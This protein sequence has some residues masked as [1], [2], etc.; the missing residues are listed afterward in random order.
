M[1]TVANRL[2]KRLA[3]IFSSAIFFNMISCSNP[4][5]PGPAP[6]EDTTNL[7][8]AARINGGFY[9]TSDYSYSK[10]SKGY[11]LTSRYSNGDVAFELRLDTLYVHTFKVGD[12]GV[13]LNYSTAGSDKLVYVATDGTL[14]I[15]SI[16][17]G[18]GQMEGTFS[19]TGQAT[20]SPTYKVSVTNG[21]FSKMP[22][23]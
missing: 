6:A 11:V 13:L 21:N 12:K 2:L 18:N 22:L 10:L 8:F 7:G 9:T 15:K 3:Y 16:I 17:S 23:K 4:P 1:K 20:S 5:S 19:F 14:D